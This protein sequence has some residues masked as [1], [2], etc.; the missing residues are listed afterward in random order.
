MATTT[1]TVTTTKEYDE[2]GNVVKETREEITN[3]ADHQNINWIP[4]GRAH[5]PTISGP[6]YS[7]STSGH[8]INS[9]ANLKYTGS[10]SIN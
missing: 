7:Y 5:Y 6:Y 4:C 8:G 10:T 1:K 3:T 9:A 2:D